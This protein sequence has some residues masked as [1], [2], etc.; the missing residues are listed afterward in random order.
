LFAQATAAFEQIGLMEVDLTFP[1]SLLVKY[2][3]FDTLPQVNPVGSAYSTSG[4]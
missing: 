2:V 3:S 4:L 1:K